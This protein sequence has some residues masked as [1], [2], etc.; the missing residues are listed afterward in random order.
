MSRKTTIIVAPTAPTELDARQQTALA[1]LALGLS[2]TAAAGQAGVARETLSGWVNHDELFIGALSESRCETWDMVT[3]KLRAAAAVAAD[4][5]LALLQN[6]N[7]AIR[8]RAAA[9]ILAH[10]SSTRPEKITPASVRARD[11][12]PTFW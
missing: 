9:L 6:E 12:F 2:I 1:G 3:D 10:V 8:L 5:V 11:A 4:E 7:P